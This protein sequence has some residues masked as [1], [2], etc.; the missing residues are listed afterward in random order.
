MEDS[1]HNPR[2][3]KPHVITFREIVD[4]VLDYYHEPTRIDDFVLNQLNQ[5]ND[6]FISI[7]LIRYFDV[8]R[9][10]DSRGVRQYIRKYVGGKMLRG[11][12]QFGMAEYIEHTHP[13]IDEK[14]LTLFAIVC[15]NI[16]SNTLKELIQVANDCVV[17]RNNYYQMMRY[18]SPMSNIIER[19]YDQ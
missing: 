2:S 8:D 19:I 14:D 15:E 17:T 7:V 12:P 3:T 11:I 18:V 1:T 10:T 13:S 4:N 6:V 5:N 16:L 9:T